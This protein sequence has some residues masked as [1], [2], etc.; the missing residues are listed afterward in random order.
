LVGDHPGTIPVEFG[1]KGLKVSTYVFVTTESNILT[2][3]EDNALNNGFQYLS[4]L[5]DCLVVCGRQ[6]TQDVWLL[7]F[8]HPPILIGSKYR[9]FVDTIL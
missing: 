3:A 1:Q 2:A 6:G 5:G 7:P 4:V 8:L 9:V